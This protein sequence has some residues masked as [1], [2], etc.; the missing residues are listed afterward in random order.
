[1]KQIA[2]AAGQAIVK[3]GQLS[4]QIVLDRRVQKRILRLETPKTNTSV[5]RP[6]LSPTC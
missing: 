5:R 2:I 1:M 4:R 6:L 3:E